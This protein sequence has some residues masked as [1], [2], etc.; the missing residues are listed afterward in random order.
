MFVSALLFVL[1]GLLFLF[2]SSLFLSELTESSD[3]FE[4][5]KLF[6]EITEVS[7]SLSLFFSSII[8]LES[9]FS[10]CLSFSLTLFEILLAV[11]PLLSDLAEELS[12]VLKIR[13]PTIPIIKI[14]ITAIKII[15]LFLTFD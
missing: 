15:F 7:S 5:F 1:F 13:S 11:F 3:F 12:I 8:P 9:S 4:I 10:F 6:L 2:S 14:Q